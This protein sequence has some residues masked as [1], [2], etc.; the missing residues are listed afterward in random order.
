MK[1]ENGR[2]ELVVDETRRPPSK[3]SSLV[4]LSGDS[5][6]GI[7]H[8]KLVFYIYTA[9][10]NEHSP[11]PQLVLPLKSKLVS[12]LP[13]SRL[14]LLLLV[15]NPKIHE[16]LDSKSLEGLQVRGDFEDPDFARKKAE[17]RFSRLVSISFVRVEL[18]RREGLT[19]PA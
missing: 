19:Y 16:V 4:R 9:T 2:R 13:S 12:L 1:E 3:Q 15:R 8:I 18:I 17:S 11:P 10:S 6:F 7:N 5:S 14:L